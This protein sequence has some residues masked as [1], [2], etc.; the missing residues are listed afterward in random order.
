MKK[1]KENDSSTIKK[2]NQE[3]LHIKEKTQ[4]ELSE[5]D[6]LLTT[7]EKELNTL[8]IHLAEQVKDAEL[9]KER[10]VIEKEREMISKT[11]ELR[12]TLDIIKEEKYNLQLELSRFKK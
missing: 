12:N 10:A 3:K 4:K 7:Q 1:E 11:E 8:R 2:L 5:K 6:S 9:I